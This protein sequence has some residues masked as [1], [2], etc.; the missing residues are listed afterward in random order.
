MQRTATGAA[1]PEL[2]CVSTITLLPLLLVPN[3]PAVIALR[4]KAE[5]ISASLYWD[6]IATGRLWT[7]DLA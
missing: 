3:Q 2:P 7:V 6:T 1:W 5:V 4:G